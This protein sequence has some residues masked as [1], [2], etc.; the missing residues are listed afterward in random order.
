MVG[1]VTPRPVAGRII[2]RMTMS[3]RQQ[4]VKDIVWIAT[5]S[6]WEGRTWLS[7]AFSTEDGDVVFV[8]SDIPEE[9][10]R[11]LQH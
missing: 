9:I 10:K 11:R 7:T 8:T 2:T 1:T 3:K 4:R 6:E 5:D